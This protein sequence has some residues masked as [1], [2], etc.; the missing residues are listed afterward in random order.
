MKVVINTDG[1][2]RGNPGL[3]GLGVYMSKEDGTPIGGFKKF[4]GEATNNVAE[5]RAL[6][7]GLDEAANAGARQVEV[8]ADSELMIK[9]LT[10]VYKIKNADM[11]TLA[12]IVRE[13]E[14]RFARVTYKHVPRAQNS[15]ADKLAN[16]AIDERVP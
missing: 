5:Y 8:R 14:K 2:S 4:I 16:E 13:K 11:Q 15:V 10:G 9:Q 3:A 1:A 6:I 7:L 12:Q